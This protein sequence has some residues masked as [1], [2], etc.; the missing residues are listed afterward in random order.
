[1]KLGHRLGMLG[2]GLVLVVAACGGD[3]ENASGDVAF[4][5]TVEL[6]PGLDYDTGLQPAG[7]PVQASFAVTAQGEAEVLAS[8]T[9]EGDELAGQAG[10]GRLRV[11][12]SF[13]LTGELKVDI[14]GLPGYEGP[15]PGLDD[16]AIDFA[17]EA[18]FD[19]FSIDDAIDAT[20]AIPATTLP[21]I[22]L[23]GGI[24]GEL[25][26]EIE[27]G[28]FVAA[29]FTGVCIGVDGT[30]AGYAGSLMHSGSLMLKPRIDISVP[31]VGSQSFDLPTVTLPVDLGASPMMMT[32]DGVGASDD[33]F[34]TVGG[35]SVDGGSATSSSSG[36]GGHAGQGGGATTTSTNATTSG[37]GGA[38]GT[39]P[40]T[41][42]SG[43][44]GA[45]GA[46]MACTTSFD[47]PPQHDCIDNQ[48][49]PI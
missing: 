37:A 35:C 16:V 31:V 9:R 4:Q 25:V 42:S 10:S 15:I 30:R 12:G 48:C 17:D 27:E 39:G 19:P 21:A 28:S 36:G 33:A 44:G 22:P 43:M 34:P 2:Y 5:G 29:S 32:S 1:M 23:P 18:S 24:P 11:A 7:S 6:L 8:A 26:L 47:C 40:T 46:G 49:Q 38:G 41:T 13:A 20:A 45:G 3:D 14:S